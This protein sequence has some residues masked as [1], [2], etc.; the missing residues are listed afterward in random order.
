MTIIIKNAHTDKNATTKATPAHISDEHK[1]IID[2]AVG[3]M[4]REYGNCLKRLAKE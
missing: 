2:Y 4:F 3:R 1:K